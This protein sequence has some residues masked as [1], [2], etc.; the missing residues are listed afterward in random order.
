MTWDNSDKHT[1]SIKINNE[2]SNIQEWLYINELSLKV[3]KT[4]YMIFHKYQR[5]IKS[6]I[7]DVKMNNQSIERVPE[8]NFRGLTIH[9]HLDWNA[10]IQKIS[11]KIAKSV[12]PN[13]HRY[14]T[15]SNTTLNHPVTNLFGSEKCVRYHLLRLIQET[16]SNILEKSGLA[17]LYWIQYISYKNLCTELQ[18]W[19]KPA[20]LLHVP[21]CTK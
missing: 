16:D 19:M 1:L 12:E 4:N 9:G 11:N 13:V 5:D 17:L 20:K 14:N 18:V 10:H 15:R 3:N 8:F 21:K 2:L 7:P 6:C